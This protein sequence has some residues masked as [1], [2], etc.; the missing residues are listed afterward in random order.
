M[1]VILATLNDKEQIMALYRGMIGTPGCTWSKNYPNEDLFAMDV[2]SSNLFCIKN[3][4]NEVI[5]TVSVDQDKEVE[6]LSVWT[7]P[8]KIA[9]LARVAVRSDYQ[10][11]G[12]ARLLLTQTMAEL[13][14]RNYQGAHFLVSETNPKALASYKKL[15]FTL[16]GTSTLYGEHWLCY[17]KIL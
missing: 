16:C 14:T 10:N 11:Q 3:Q 7:L 1:K 6:E 12:I 9:E 4:Q 5:A 13:K 8:G 15:N 17:E 2:A